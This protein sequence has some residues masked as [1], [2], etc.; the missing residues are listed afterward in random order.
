M[1]SLCYRHEG[2]GRCEEFERR[3]SVA[4][5]GFYTP[6]GYKDQ[7]AYRAVANPLYQTQTCPESVLAGP[8][9]LSQVNTTVHASNSSDLIHKELGVP[10][11]DISTF[12]FKCYIQICYML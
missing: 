12:G 1:P 8:P 6:D 3:S 5:C 2:D 9:D 7:W 11:Q 10:E 4:D